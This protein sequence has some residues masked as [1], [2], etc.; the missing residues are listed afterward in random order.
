MLEA[1]VNNY[2]ELNIA[3]V[4][5]LNDNDDLRGI[6]KRMRDDSGYIHC[7]TLVAIYGDSWINPA[8]SGIV[9]PAVAQVFSCTEDY[10]R[11]LRREGKIDFVR[12][13]YGRPA[14]NVQS[15][16][17]WLEGHRTDVTGKRRDAGRKGAEKR[18]KPMYV[19]PGS[20]L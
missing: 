13:A 14:S 20:L 11:Q 17:N 19:A 5:G 7:D 9:G 12:W 16:A 18:W 4:W 10:L 8:S 2:G 6:P 3:A 1:L 15:V